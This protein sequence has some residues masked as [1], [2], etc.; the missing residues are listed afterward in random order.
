VVSR[1]QQIIC[2]DWTVGSSV[3][4]GWS[5]AAF[6]PPKKEATVEPPPGR[7]SY[8][9]GLL[10]HKQV[11][12]KGKEKASFGEKVKSRRRG[13]CGGF[14]I[15]RKFAGGFLTLTQLHIMAMTT[16]A[17]I[18]LT[19]IICAVSSSAIKAGMNWYVDQSLVDQVEAI[20]SLTHDA[21]GNKIDHRRKPWC[22]MRRLITAYKSGDSEKFQE[23]KDAIKELKESKEADDLQDLEDPEENGSTTA[24]SG[25]TGALDSYSWSP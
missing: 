9:K 10:N 4:V 7:L 17:T 15:T 18:A 24:V 19:K 22:T 16:M 1:T 25:L 13:F 6:G 3:T 8:K 12:K 2:W 11:Q 5:R 20:Y 14:R 23:L 21:K